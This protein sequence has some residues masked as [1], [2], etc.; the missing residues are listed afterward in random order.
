MVGPYVWLAGTWNVAS[1]NKEMD[2]W[3]FVLLI[4]LN[5]SS[6]VRSVVTES[7]STGLMDKRAET[8]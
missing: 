7:D 8:S 1:A 5:V 3:F 6:L 4:N 2:F